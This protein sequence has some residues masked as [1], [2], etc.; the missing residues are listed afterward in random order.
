METSKRSFKEIITG[1]KFYFFYIAAVIALLP[2]GELVSELFWGEQF[3]S[4]PRILALFG[5]AGLASVIVFFLDGAKTPR[6]YP[7]D[8][9]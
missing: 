3:V 8:I 4:Q 2:L 9:F 7:T 5:G 1:E 6:F